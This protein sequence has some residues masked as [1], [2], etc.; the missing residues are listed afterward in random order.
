MNIVQHNML[1]PLAR[2][3]YAEMLRCNGITGANAHRALGI[4]SASLSK[5]ICDLESV[6]IKVD[7]LPRTDPLTGRKYTKYRLQRSQ[8]AA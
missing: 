2:T 8:V 3:V 5:R 7:R 6:G 4:S 1:S